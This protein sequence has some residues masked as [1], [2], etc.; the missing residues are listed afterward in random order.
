M[1]TSTAAN[2][3]VSGGPCV[4]VWA[5]K[6]VHNWDSPWRLSWLFLCPFATKC[7]LY[8]TWQVP[9][10]ALF[11]PVTVCVFWNPPQ[12]HGNAACYASYRQHHCRPSYT[13]VTMRAWC[14]SQEI[15]PG[16]LS[17]PPP[18]HFLFS[19]FFFLTCGFLKSLDAFMV[20]NKDKLGLCLV[21][22]VL[23]SCHLA[24]ARQLAARDVALQARSLFLS[25]LFWCCHISCQWRVLRRPLVCGRVQGHITP[26]WQLD[27]HYRSSNAFLLT[28]HICLS[29][30]LPLSLPLSVL[31]FLIFLSL[32]PLDAHSFAFPVL[33]ASLSSRLLASSISSRRAQVISTSLV[34]FMFHFYMLHF[35]QASRALQ[36]DRDLFNLEKT[37]QFVCVS[38]MFTNESHLIT[39]T[40]IIVNIIQLHMVNTRELGQDGS[41]SFL[42]CFFS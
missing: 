23:L 32:A 5:N 6:G 13:L 39:T 10:C 29:S 19:F 36:S 42:D 2:M 26:L 9:R 40:H 28:L 38:C 16:L 35:C 4:S 34:S 27:L 15:L 24:T 22:G 25:T 17:P 8:V 3:S 21:P 33:L 30:S 11:K 37:V 1:V 7:V 31:V 12:T 18:H 20:G 41:C 14:N